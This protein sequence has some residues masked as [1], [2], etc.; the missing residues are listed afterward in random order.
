MQSEPSQRISFS[1]L[2]LHV[3]TAFSMHVPAERNCSKLRMLE[4]QQMG[5]SASAAVCEMGG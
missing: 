2:E 3:Y 1:D 4:K 5:G